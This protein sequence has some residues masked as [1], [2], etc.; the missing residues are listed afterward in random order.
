[1]YKPKTLGMKLKQKCFQFTL[2]RKMYIV[3]TAKACPECALTP[4]ASFE[5]KDN[6][7]MFDLVFNKCA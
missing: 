3:E 1:M 5:S 7:Q 2:L 6:Y 4:I